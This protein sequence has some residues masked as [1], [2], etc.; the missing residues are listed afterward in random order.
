MIHPPSR[1]QTTEAGSQNIN[2]P[3]SPLSGIQLTGAEYWTQDPSD[4]GSLGSRQ[5]N[6]RNSN[7][8]LQPNS[9]TLSPNTR[10]VPLQYR[11]HVT[12][13][14]I[15]FEDASMNWSDGKKRTIG[16]MHSEQVSRYVN[17]GDV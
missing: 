16:L 2:F 10:S 6:A 13:R 14:D 9:P 1:S 8:S 15:P 11:S 17:K 3:Q 12:L 5:V 7:E 4:A